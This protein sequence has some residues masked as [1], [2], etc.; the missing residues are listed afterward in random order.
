M[1]KT[2]GLNTLVSDPEVRLNAVEREAGERQRDQ[3]RRNQMMQLVEKD[4]G[5]SR[6]GLGELLSDVH[7]NMSPLDKAA[8]YTALIPLLGDAVGAVADTVH[9][10]EDPSLT[11]AGFLLAGLLPFVPSGGVTRNLRQ[12]LPQAPNYLGTFYKNLPVVGKK[13]AKLLG[14]GEGSAKGLVNLAEARYSPK[15]RGI[16]KEHGVSVA[17]TKIAKKAM[18]DFKDPKI[19]EEKVR[20]SGKQAIGQF[21]QTTLMGQQYKHPSKFHKISEGLDEVAFGNFN[22][23]DYHRIMG[24]ATGLRREDL[25]S[26]FKH[27]GSKDIQNINPGKNYQMTVRRSNTQAAGNL[28]NFA[29]QR[30]IFGGSTVADL[31]K[32]VF[33]GKK[34]KSNEEFLEALQAHKVGVRNPEEVLKGRPA[35]V[36]GNVNSDAVELGGVN[37]MSSIKKDGT[38]VSFMSDEHDLFK[39]KLPK[40][41]RMISISTPITIDILKKKDK[42][43]RISSKVARSQKTLLE[44]KRSKAKEVIEELSKYPGVDITLPTPKGMTKAQFYAIQAVANMSPANPDYSRI[45]KDVGMFAPVR[46]A[47][48][49]TGSAVREKKKGGGSVMGRNPYDYKPKAI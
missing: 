23:N 39:M 9:L 34:F 16:F 33:K 40:G 35:I 41:E 3:A 29:F 27:I 47:K 37:Y 12:A 36:T 28:D 25:N 31:R 15:A 19:P 5:R 1:A 22:A 44:A 21:R 43:K 4:A 48:T 24:G 17:D 30:P 42:V 49:I 45:L 18:K 13:G 26:V 6:G 32:N 46:A 14:V 10:A 38:L 8:L 20:K 7:E 2:G 11:N